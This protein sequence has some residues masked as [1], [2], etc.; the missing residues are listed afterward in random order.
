V[1]DTRPVGWREVLI[2]AVVAV[3][4]VLGTDVITSTVPA[5]KEV[6]TGTPLVV[7]LLVAGTAGL[8]WWLAARRPPEV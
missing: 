5:L 1:A 7:V 8:L 6:V 3:A 4:V 2:V